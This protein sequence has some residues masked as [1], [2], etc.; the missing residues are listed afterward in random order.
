MQNKF[1]VIILGSG[2]GGSLLAAGLARS[3]VRV[4]LLDTQAHP[5]FAIGESS[6]PLADQTL[7]RISR[8]YALPEILPLVRYGTWKRNLP[9]L[10]CGKKR[11]FSYFSHTPGQFPSP[12]DFHQRRLLV[13][14]SA[15]DE[16]SD[17]HWL[18][19]DVDNFLYQTAVGSGVTNYVPCTYKLSEGR[20]GWHIT[21]GQSVDSVCLESDFL[22]D[23]TGSSNALLKHLKIPDISDQLKTHSGTLF[24][25][26]ENVPSC[27]EL[28]NSLDIRTREFPF[29]CD[30]AAVHH[31]LPFGWMWQLRFDDGT[32]SAGV[33]FDGKH[34][35]LFSDSFTSGELTSAEQGNAHAI[36]IWKRI[37][38]DFPFLKQQFENANI[39][40]PVEGL[41]WVPRIQRLASAAAGKNWAALPNSAGF[42][43]PLHSTGIAHTLVCV[44][45][46][47]DVLVHPGNH[48]AKMHEYS[49]NVI[50][51]IQL[52]DELVEG[53]YA[54]LPS[55]ELWCDW[56]MI[57][58]AA[59]TTMENSDQDPRFN[60]V[61]SKGQVGPLPY[62]QSS[63]APGFL[64]ANDSAF[65]KM[66]C[67]ARYQL[68]MAKD[69]TMSSFDYRV[70]LRRA[71]NPWNCVGLL[72]DELR[73]LYAD[74]AAP[75]T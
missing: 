30:D 68:E 64:R 25:H 71:I 14:A 36:S 11:G 3:G 41:R 12:V 26:F 44:E 56:S 38:S 48:L 45:R 28:L 66:I 74:T 6:T 10:L 43:D 47:L 69:G 72:N 2:F 5:R 13:A 19:S 61:E 62:G 4:A 63:C 34:R 24:A 21:I 29:H 35:H 73:G 57:Y 75:E 17:T 1:D 67:D 7:A 32:V 18:R 55:F 60:D 49:S 53:C 33:M 16:F 65:R 42:V 51:E 9:W 39:V 59:V 52:V 70:W 23:A 20:N 27:E 54:A 46:L 50:Q 15:S 22:V 8:R 58:F 31:V 37:I 40:R